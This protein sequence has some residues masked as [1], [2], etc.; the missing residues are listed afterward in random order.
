M[1]LSYGETVG[2]NIDHTLSSLPGC[3]YTF[4]SN[5]WKWVKIGDDMTQAKVKSPKP[6]TIFTRRETFAGF[7]DVDINF[8][9]NGQFAHTE[10]GILSGRWEIGKL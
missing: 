5:T 3:P 7:T 9:G 4:P 10:A 2:G 6:T 8:Y 1:S